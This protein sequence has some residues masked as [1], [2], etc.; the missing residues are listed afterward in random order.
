MATL[1]RGLR[2]NNP[3]NIEKNNIAWDGLTDGPDE[4]FATF[5]SP[6]YGIRA[7]AKIL[8]NYEKLYGLNTVNG[9]INRFAPPYEN[10]TNAYAEHVAKELGVGVDE[11]IN[12]KD[13]LFTM[14]ST[15]IKHENGV[16]PYSDAQIANGIAM[17]V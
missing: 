11:P 17:A 8:L 9:I 4:R 2:N 12:V 16:N 5:E 1:A 13:N 14:V 10:N 3:L 6:E 15:M 7:G